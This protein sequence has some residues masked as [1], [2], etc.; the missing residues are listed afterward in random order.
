M[1]KTEKFL[2]EARM[3]MKVV[4]DMRSLAD[5]IQKVCAYVSNTMQ[6]TQMPPEE[7]KPLITLEQI[8][9]VLADKSRSGFTNEVREIIKRHGADRLSAVDPAE[10]EAMI[11]ETENLK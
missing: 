5:S 6:E 8:R 9:G 11:A 7:K 1:E 2:E 10:Y 3:M 4:E